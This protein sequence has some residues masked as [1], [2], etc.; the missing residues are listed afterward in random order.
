MRDDQQNAEDRYA[1][2]RALNF[3]DRDTMDTDAR[4]AVL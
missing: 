4:N 3:P 1:A 2:D